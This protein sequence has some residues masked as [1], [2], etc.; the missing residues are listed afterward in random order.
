MNM[1]V[2]VLCSIAAIC[3][4][5]LLQAQD[6]GSW[7]DDI[8]SL[9]SV[10]DELY[11]ELLPKCSAL[12]GVGRGI[13]GFAAIWY[14]G[15]RVWRHIGNAE[16]IDLYPLFRPFVLASIILMFPN[17]LALVTGI[18]KPV[19]LTT[20]QL[21]ENSDKAVAILLKQKEE[22]IKTT[23]VYQMY[24]GDN[25]AG[26]YDKWYKFTH[27]EDPNHVDED[28][29]DGIGNGIRFEMA[30]MGYNFR[31][32]VKE[33]IA[34]V[35][36]LLFAAASLCINT[37]RT[38]NLIILA[39]LGPLV[40]GLAVF[41]GFQ[42]TLKHWVARYVNVFLWLP[43]CNLFGFLIGTIQEKMLKIDLDQINQLGD[44][45]FSRA[46]AGYMVFMIIGIIGY[47]TIPSIANYVMFVGGGDALT[48]KTSGFAGATGGA[49]ASGTMAAGS[50][51]AG[52]AAR[53]LA[54]AGRGVGNLAN[55]SKDM[56]D[57]YNSE[58]PNNPNSAWSKA[59]KKY[60]NYL[61]NKLKGND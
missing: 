52:A 28:W 55:Y 44:T 42:H 60:G 15:S 4:P 22:A 43:I 7:A 24:A 27:P 47:T 25:G 36:Q 13:A 54:Q 9:H 56:L 35:L 1:W 23:D 51:V 34:E 33:V 41:D 5:M 40:F 26:N 3:L 39:L 10:L 2:R 12:I 58:T 14:I 32:Q 45:F 19:E 38:F 16:S 31:N 61:K 20:G 18:L 11:A 30:K 21:V 49:A 8:K 6:D 57:G 59:G 50:F 17:F 46:D 53:G 29:L 37:M 48:G